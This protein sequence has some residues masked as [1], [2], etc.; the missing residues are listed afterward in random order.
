MWEFSIMNDQH[1]TISQMAALQKAHEDALRQN[2]DELLAIYDGMLE[3]LL[4]ADIETK[5]L[6]RANA[7]IC[8]MLGYTEA[9]LLSLSVMD[10]HPPEVVASVLSRPFFGGEGPRI[11]SGE[12]IFLR[13]D[14]ST[15]PA[16]VNC[17]PLIYDGRH[18]LM[19][20][21]R[22][23]T[24]QKKWKEAL[25]WERRSLWRMLRASDHERQIIAYDIHDGLAQYLA[26]AGMQLQAFDFL[27][28][29]SPDQAE[30]VYKTVLDLVHQAH[31]EARRLI[32]DVRHPILDVS[33]LE[34]AIVN[35]ANVQQ[36]RGGLQIEC[37]WDTKFER[38]PKILENAIFRIVQ[39]ALTNACKYSRSEK[40]KIAIVQEGE[41][42]RVEVRDWGIGFDP[43]GGEM[44]HFGLEGIRERVRLLGGSL[45]IESSPGCGTSIQV[46]VPV[47]DKE[48]LEFAFSSHLVP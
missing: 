47:F 40:V 6:L 30:E 27:K 32:S 29:A 4:I 1:E 22:D 37:H 7:S 23:I 33:G 36:Q 42:L 35:L 24:E 21:F 28:G 11:V 41:N 46:L 43:K 39:E 14:G 48:I 31:S 12:I 10:I 25:D 3:G 26:A 20:I 18:C 13:K 17:T 5:R 34:S 19:G 45:A 2:H 9:E 15:F 44:G 16:E 38:L 8:R